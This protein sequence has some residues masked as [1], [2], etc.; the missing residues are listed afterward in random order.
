M[1]SVR[2]FWIFLINCALA[3]SDPG[4]L[5]SVLRAEGDKIV[6]SL[7]DLSQR[8]DKSEDNL[9]ILTAVHT[10]LDLQVDISSNR[11]CQCESVP[12]LC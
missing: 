5:A 3:V 6:S 7:T 12:T 9:Q 1:L 8:C 11:Q 10:S 2:M 4:D